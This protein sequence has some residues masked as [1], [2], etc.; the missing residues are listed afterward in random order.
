MR[1]DFDDDRNDS[2]ADID[3]NDDDG[4]YVRNVVLMMFST[5]TRTPMTK[6]TMSITAKKDKRQCRRNC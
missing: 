5:A 4:D 3:T 6:L 2:D 1:Y